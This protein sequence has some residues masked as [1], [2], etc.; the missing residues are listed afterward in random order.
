M[1]KVTTLIILSLFVVT[2]SYGQKQPGIGKYHDFKEENVKNFCWNSTDPASTD[3]V[4]PKEW[5]NEPA[6]FLYF[7]NNYEIIR[8][9]SK[10]FAITYIAHYR[11]KLQDNSALERFSEIYYSKN[12]LGDYSLG[13]QVIRQKNYLGIKIIKPDGSEVLVNSDDFIK[14]KDGGKKIAIPNL[15]VG[16]IIDYYQYNY[17]YGRTGYYPITDRFIIGGSFPIVHFKYQLLTNKHWDVMFTT[18]PN[19]PKIKEEII[20]KKYFKFTVTGSDFPSAAN[21]IWNL[22]FYDFPYIKLFVKSEQNHLSAKKS[23]PLRT[24]KIKTETIK[25]AFTTYY[26]QEPKAGNEYNSFLRYLKKHG[27]TNLTKEK[28]LEEYFYYLRHI[29]VNM[30]YIY[31]KYNN[32]L[33]SANSS[34]EAT[35]HDDDGARYVSSRAFTSH[36][37]YGLKKM[38]IRYEVIAAPMRSSGQLSDLLSISETSYLIK[39][40]LK[41]PVYFYKPDAFTSYNDLPSTVEGVEVYSLYSSDGKVRNIRVKKTTLP[42]STN[43]DNSSS[44]NIDV[45]FDKEDPLLL[46]INTQITYKGEPMRFIKDL[47]VDQFAMI[48]DENELYGTKKWGDMEESKD[49]LRVQMEEFTA[50]LEEERKEN[51]LGLAEDL[52][53]TEEIELGE[54]GNINTGN[55]AGEYDLQINFDCKAG[56]LVKKVGNNY[57]IKAGQLLGGQITID[58]EDMER[59]VNIHMNFPRTFNYV[60]NI[61]IPDGYEARGLE[62]FNHNIENATG[63]LVSSAVEKD[64]VITIKF[65]KSYKHNFEKAEDWG[66]MKDFL[67]PASLFPS[68]EILLRKL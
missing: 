65:S 55:Q 29:Y 61:N 66:L 40:K 8:L 17:D 11:I 56:E 38:K 3:T 49:K 41:E 59:D 30:H 12:P 57:I 48:W 60:I 15:E 35:S 51:F 28:K 13:Y 4:V 46:D 45:N 18:G 42:V 19:G 16:D 64:G 24:T 63:Y 34:G 2:I 7:E 62:N 23:R 39:A 47:Y 21:V 9:A 44:F 5:L 22:P 26:E 31:D 58:D 50:S 27:K 6:V 25:T 37:I 54:Y 10:A 53:D 1:K 67:I 32:G 43:V 20:D 68:K 14:E 33:A 36:L 52:F